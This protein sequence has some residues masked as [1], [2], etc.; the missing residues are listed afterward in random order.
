MQTE[1]F[2]IKKNRQFQDYAKRKK[3]QNTQLTW[4]QERICQG[5]SYGKRRDDKEKLH[6]C[7]VAYEELP[8]E[9]KIFDRKTS[10]AT[11][12]LILKLG[13]QIHEK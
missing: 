4:A 11:L 13:F 12:K 3:S 5:W 6:P 7:L 1:L 2:R 9:E 8:E 10:L